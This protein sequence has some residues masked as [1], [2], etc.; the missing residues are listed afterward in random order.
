MSFSVCPVSLPISQNRSKH[1]KKRNPLSCIR[2][3]RWSFEPS[4]QQSR[5]L[6]VLHSQHYPWA[7]F[8]VFVLIRLHSWVHV[9]RDLRSFYAQVITRSGWSLDV[10]SWLVIFPIYLSIRHGLYTSNSLISPP[11]LCN[12]HSLFRLEQ[13]RQYNFSQNPAKNGT[14]KREATLK[15]Q[16][17][18]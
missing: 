15:Y 5:R 18:H 6:W 7:K 13:N 12:N 1:A 11:D 8:H 2:R 3:A 10:M 4:V 17:V 9:M 14:T 16:H